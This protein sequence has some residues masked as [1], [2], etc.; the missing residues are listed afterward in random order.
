MYIKF[1]ISDLNPDYGMG[2]LEEEK[3][4]DL[5]NKV[6]ISRMIGFSF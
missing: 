5:N 2:R 1:K 3:K 4:I 6:L